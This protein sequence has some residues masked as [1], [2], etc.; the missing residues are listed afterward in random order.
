[1]TAGST[2]DPA[3]FAAAKQKGGAAGGAA[4]GAEALRT[5]KGVFKCATT[6]TRPPHELVEGIEHAL[7]VL[8]TIKFKRKGSYLFRCADKKS[9]VRFE[10]EVVN[11]EKL[12]GMHGIRFAPYSRSVC[13][14]VVCLFFSDKSR[15]SFPEKFFQATHLFTSVLRKR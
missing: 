5:V 8:G 11:V 6:S 4:G 15:F 3:L 10:I 9:K 1:M 12:D 2:W 14:S 7:V 13:T